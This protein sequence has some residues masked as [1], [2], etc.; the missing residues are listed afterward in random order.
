MARLL[1]DYPDTIEQVVHHLAIP[2][3]FDEAAFQHVVKTNSIHISFDT[4]ERL[5]KISLNAVGDEGW[6]ARHR[7][8]ADALVQLMEQ[9][10]LI[11]PRCM[12]TVQLVPKTD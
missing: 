7:A 2:T 9:R 8:L 3:R 1:R 4:C 12:C 11:P 5:A 10:V 6:I